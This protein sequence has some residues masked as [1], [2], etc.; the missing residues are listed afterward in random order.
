MNSDS[1][2]LNPYS[3]QSDNVSVL[4]KFIQSQDEAV[5]INSITFFSGD[6]VNVGNNLI[7]QKT[8]KNDEALCKSMFY[9]KDKDFVEIKSDIRQ[10]INTDWVFFAFVISFILLTIFTFKNRKR[11]FQIFKAFALIHF[12]NQLIREG[13]IIREFF[14]YP[15]LLVYYISLTFLVSNILQNFFNLEIDLNK[16]LYIFFAI[17]LFFI[18]KVLVIKILGAVFQTKNETFE[19]FIN[20]IIFSVVFSMFFLLFVFILEYSSPFIS[21]IVL[22]IVIAISIL[23][24]LYRLIRGFIIGLNSEGYNLNYLFLYL[25]TVELLPIGISIKLIL[26]FYL[27]GDF[28]K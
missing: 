11:I 5:S 26:N 13:N 8:F 16:S 3:Y 23:G 20:D 17:V 12:T 14:I 10:N 27:T 18:I 25:C 9:Q 28:L 6:S 24:Y 21:N 7:K 1:L 15:L 22:Y 4:S 19:F 2:T